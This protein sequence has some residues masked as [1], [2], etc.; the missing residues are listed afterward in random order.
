MKEFSL[1]GVKEVNVITTPVEKN[2]EEIQL[3]GYSIIP[4]I[5][6]EKELEIIR[7]KIDEI[8]EIQVKEVGDEKLLE[9]IG[10]SNNA[11]CPLIYDEIFLTHVAANEKVLDIVKGM[12]GEYFILMLQ[13]AVINKPVTEKKGNVWAYHRDLNYQHFISSRPL[14]ISALFCIDNFSEV[15]GGTYVLPYTQK[16]EKCPSVE[17]IQEHEVVVNAMAGSVIIFDSMMFHR[18]GLNS[19]GNLRRAINNMY[20]VPFIKQ[21]ISL[22][23]ALKGKYKEDPFYNRFLGY[24]CES[25][26][27]VLAFRQKRISRIQTT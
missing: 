10:D 6:N 20:T 25:D 23:A 26:E 8:Y 1:F 18:A 9:K 22:P 21:Q 16:F 2:I 15:T 11:R 5:L 27:S 3:K 14:S 13:N 12:L 4:G 17:Y 24:D 19:S 7:K